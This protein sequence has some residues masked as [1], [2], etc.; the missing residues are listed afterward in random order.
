MRGHLIAV[1]DVAGLRTELISLHHDIPFPGHFMK[2]NTVHLLRQ[3]Y[4]WPSMT[5]DVHDYVQGLG[6]CLQRMKIS[7]LRH[8][9]LLQ[10]L[11]IPEFRWGR[12]S[13]DLITHLPPTKKG[14]TAIVVFVDGLSQMVHFA[15]AWD[16]MGS[17]EFANLFLREISR[18]HGLPKQI[19]SD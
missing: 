14:H 15:P 6:M 7:P 17:E 8:A 2:E 4:W 11:P 5:R 10:P 19:V 16:D 9:G 1:P 18:R 12:V 3:S 13:V